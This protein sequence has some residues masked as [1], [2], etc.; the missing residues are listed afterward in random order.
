MT[1][2]IPERNYALYLD[3]IDPRI[4]NARP[5]HRWGN[6]DIPAKIR[7]QISF[8]WQ[9]LNLFIS[10]VIHLQEPGRPIIDRNK[11]GGYVLSCV[12]KALEPQ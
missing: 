1:E 6:D 9:R 5:L 4:R 7:D 12:E 3:H 8:K 10:K 11:A 2:L